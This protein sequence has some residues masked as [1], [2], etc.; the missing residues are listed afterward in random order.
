MIIGE[1]NRVKD[2]H[3][4]KKISVNSA[5]WEIYSVRFSVGQDT[6]GNS[7]NI[8]NMHRKKGKILK[9]R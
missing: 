3:I 4:R 7:S 1:R 9:R 5:D 2:S 6:V 8:R